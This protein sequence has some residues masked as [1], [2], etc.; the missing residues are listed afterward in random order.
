M[1][2]C[3]PRFHFVTLVLLA[4]LTLSAD[5]HRSWSVVGGDEKVTH[6]STLDQINRDN[7][8]ELEVAWIYRS[9]DLLADDNEYWGGSTIQSNPIIVEGWL[10]TTTPTLDVVALD[11]ATGG[12]I[13]RYTPWKG[14]IGGGYNRGLAYW[15]SEDGADRRLYYTVGNELI[16]LDPWTGKPVFS[17]GERGR[18]SM[19]KGLIPEHE[20]RGG[21]VSP[22]APAIYKDLVIVAGMGDW[23][24]PG[25]VSAYD[26]ITGDR[27]WIFHNIPHPGEV[28][29]DSW[30][31]PDYWRDGFGANAWGG[32][33]VDTE[34]GMVYFPIGQAKPDLHRPNP[35]DHLFGNS[36]VALDAATGAYRWHFQEIRHDLWDMEPPCPPVLFDL[37]INGETVPGMAL[38]S[39][40]GFTWL[41]NRI[42]GENYTEYELRPV[43]SSDLTTEYASPVQPWVTWPEPFS[44]I[45]VK[46]DEYSNISPEAEAFSKRRLAEADLGWLTPPNTK[47]IIYYGV[48]GGAEWP[49]PAYDPERKLLFINSNQTPWFVKMREVVASHEGSQLYSNHCVSCHGWNRGGVADNP[50]LTD[51]NQRYDSV[52]ILESILR[53]RVGEHDDYPELDNRAILEV[54]EFL[55]DA[56]P[57]QLNH[58]GARLYAQGG[59]V[60]CHG[61]RREGGGTP[62]RPSLKN[63]GPKYPEIAELKRVIREGTGAMVGNTGFSDDELTKLANFLLGIPMEPGPED[64]EGPRYSTDRFERFLD[65]DGYPATR[66]PWGT[67]NAISMETGKIVWKVPLGE[68]SELT[69]R[70]IPPTGTENFGGPVVTSGG[71]LFIGATMDEKF[72]AF[73]SDTGAILWEYQL[74]SGGYATPS[75]YEVDG[76]QYIVIPCGGGGKPGTKSG[77][78]FVAFALPST[79]AQD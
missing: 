10:F 7:V 3:R 16:C 32:L 22:A 25:N 37:D 45:D 46:P 8:E 59:C 44:R 40:T 64:L 68:F 30:G 62:D 76:R 33:S 70:G 19:A 52:G 63:L 56:I 23:R 49:G 60:E 36:V 18:R 65:P 51:L 17:F 12:E 47:G 72:R 34:N 6:Y 53:A 2:N 75:T 43:P 26:A 14:K 29:Y 71:L 28:G 20:A 39:K 27:V 15:S 66:P 54:S 38:T 11:A 9:G 61:G 41:F 50:A 57:D 21:V 42:T 73:D 24:V 5:P 13:W 69:A 58:P 35:G 1:R 67:L 55:M 74:P 77:D 31:D 79:F 48:H 4:G 78:A